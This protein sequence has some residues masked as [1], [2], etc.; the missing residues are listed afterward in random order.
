MRRASRG[1]SSELLCITDHNRREVVYN[2]TPPVMVSL[3][4]RKISQKRRS[5]IAFDCD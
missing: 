1:L 3:H 2:S 4:F 5:P